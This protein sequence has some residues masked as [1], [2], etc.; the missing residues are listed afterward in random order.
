MAVAPEEFT[1]AIEAEMADEEAH[2]EAHV[3]A[4]EDMR[5]KRGTS[6]EKKRRT[7]G[8]RPRSS[9]VG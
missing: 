1:L 5:P 9:C 8:D 3:E 2:V 6:Q 7:R 4:Q